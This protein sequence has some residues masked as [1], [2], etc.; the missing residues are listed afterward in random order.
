M[1]A[2][3]RKLSQEGYVSMDCQVLLRR[4]QRKRKELER[5]ARRK[6]TDSLTT[7]LVYRKSC[8]LDSLIVQYMKENRQMELDFPDYYPLPLGR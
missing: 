6:G 4:I 3:R 8:E 5:L 1:V 7:G 2:R